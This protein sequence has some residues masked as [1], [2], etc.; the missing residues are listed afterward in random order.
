MKTYKITANIITGVTFA[1]C[2]LLAVQMLTGSTEGSAF[3]IPYICGLGLHFQTDGFRA[4]YG[5]IAAFMW[6]MRTLFAGEYFARHEKTEPGHNHHTGRYYIFLL[7]TLAATEGVFF[8]ADF[9][10]T[11]IFFEIMSFTS[12]VWVVQDEKPESLRTGATYLAVAVI[13]GLV[14]LMGIFLLYDATGTL[15]FDDLVNV[16]FYYGYVSSRY[17]TVAKIWAAGLCLLFGFGVVCFFCV[18]IC[19]D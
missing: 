12:Y 4:L 7:I 16:L 18:L 13:G 2:S 14:M 1:L 19:S 17:G 15:F 9:F 11:F 5:T 10:T 6:F 3:G 8:S